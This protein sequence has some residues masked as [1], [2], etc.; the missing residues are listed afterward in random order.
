VLAL[1]ADSDAAWN[2]EKY[3]TRFL[4]QDTAF[5]LAPKEL[6]ASCV[7]PV[8]FVGI[9][10]VRRGYYEAQLQ[11]LA[12]PPYSRD[13]REHHRA[14]RAGGGS[15]HRRHPADWLWM[16]RKWKYQKPPHGV[17]RLESAPR[18]IWR[19]RLSRVAKFSFGAF[20][21]Q[22]EAVLGAQA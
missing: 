13:K 8:F 9:Q 2:D 4:N 14:L 17:I 7:A 3:W 22:A 15:P 20:R 6:R 1:V 19:V 18:G 21:Q 16:Y 11:L 10:R 5:S 12:E